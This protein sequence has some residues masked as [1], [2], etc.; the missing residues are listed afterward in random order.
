MVTRKKYNADVSGSYEL[1]LEGRYNNQYEKCRV[2]FIHKE[3][4]V[5]IVLYFF[6]TQASA[7]SVDKHMK[8]VLNKI[9]F[10]G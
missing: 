2:A 6:Y 4:R 5:D 9:K 7:D 1:P 3:N 10:A 8:K